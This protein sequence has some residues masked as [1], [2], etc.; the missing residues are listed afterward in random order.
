MDSCQIWMN[1][2]DSWGKWSRRTALAVSHPELALLLALWKVPCQAGLKICKAELSGAVPVRW[3][4]RGG[5]VQRICSFGD[6]EHAVLHGQSH[7]WKRKHRKRICEFPA[8]EKVPP[9]HSL[10]HSLFALHLLSNALSL[11]Q[12]DSRKEVWNHY[13]HSW[14]TQ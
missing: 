2:V 9:S 6:V 1:V 12:G 13:F 11:L 14:R 8:S 4:G 10:T 5:T 7:T 3:P